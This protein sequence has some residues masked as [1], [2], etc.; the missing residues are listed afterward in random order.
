MKTISAKV[1]DEIYELVDELT[2]QKN[3]TKSELI[4][5][6]ILNSKITSGDREKLQLKRELLYEI[7]RIGNNINQIAKYCNTKKA[8][9][10]VAVIELIEVKKLLQELIK[11]W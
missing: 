9:D 2:K 11:K 5:Q 10:R 6:A 1:S 8:I 7:N 3:I 4:K